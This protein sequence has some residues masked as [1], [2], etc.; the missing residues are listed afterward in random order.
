MNMIRHSEKF[1]YQTNISDDIMAKGTTNLNGDYN[2]SGHA[3]DAVG[4]I[5]AR[6]KM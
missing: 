3:S 2:L 6:V 4:S 5:E 1:I